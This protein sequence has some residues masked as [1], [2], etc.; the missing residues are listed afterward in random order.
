MS[1]GHSS[2]FSLLKRCCR[3]QPTQ[4]PNAASRKRTV[5]HIPHKDITRAKGAPSRPIK[6]QVVNAKPNPRPHASRFGRALTHSGLCQYTA[7]RPKAIV[8]EYLGDITNRMSMSKRK[9]IAKPCTRRTSFVFSAVMKPPKPKTN[10]IPALARTSRSLN[11]SKSKPSTI[12][13]NFPHR[14]VGL[15]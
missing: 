9:N 5:M 10:N 6:K 15:G 7:R 2:G 14:R 13:P 11:T 1:P 8:G 4:I 12:S 3:K